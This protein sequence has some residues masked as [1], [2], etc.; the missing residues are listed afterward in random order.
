MFKKNPSMNAMVLAAGL[1]TRLRPLTELIP[2]PLVPVCNCPMLSIVMSNLYR[3]GI[4]G[5][6]V[7]THYLPE[8]I[9]TH[10]H[11][12]KFN[13]YTHIY[14]EPE[15]LGT[16]GPLINAKKLLTRNDFFILHN[17]D[18]LTNIN[19]SAMISHHF[20]SQKK[21]TMALLDGPENKVCFTQDGQVHDILESLG[22]NPPGS[23]KMTY[24]GIMIISIDIFK[25]LPAVPVNCSIIRALIDMIEAEPGVVG[26]YLEPD[27]YWNDL[28]TIEQYFNAHHNILVDHSFSLPDFVLQ[29]N[30]CIDSSVKIEQDTEISGFVSIGADSSIGKR[31]ALCNCIILPGT[32]IG[33]DEFHYNQILTPTMNIHRNYHDLKRLKILDGG[34]F[35]AGQ[36]TSLQEQGSTRGFYRVSA[37]DKSWV[38][39]LSDGMD[40]DFERFIYIGKFLSRFNFPT[41]E[42]YEYEPEEFSVLLE[43]L[44][45]N[46]VFKQ[47]QHVKNIE[48]TDKIY[49]DI[50]DTLLDFQLRGTALFKRS[51]SPI[52]RT[53]DRTYLRWE[54]G[55]FS[56]QFL[57]TFCNKTSD[58]YSRLDDEF[59]ILAEQV[60]NQP[61]IFM[62]RDFQSQNIMLHNGRVRFVDYQGAR[63]G[64]VGYDIM[65]LLNDPY[66]NFGSKQRTR[67]RKYYI[68]RLIEMAPEYSTVNLEDCLITA[69]LQRNMQAL[70][71]YAYLGL[72]VGKKQFLN[73][74]P[75]GLKLLNEGLQNLK[76]TASDLHLP[77][78]TKVVK[79]IVEN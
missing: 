38:L 48:E 22:K 34:K 31:T 56:R 59:D 46:T 10:I 5:F 69:G 65:S 70:G 39:M 3:A 49:Y 4:R 6:A 53:F 7:N 33:T 61:R 21:V 47:L 76:I 54:T 57:G 63:I 35:L 1:G 64:P 62:H 9:N 37:G 40:Q 60:S 18:I 44:G 20:A 78:I 45:N 14:H 77:E 12:S 52:L 68:S 50:I 8:M 32:T 72:T 42:I 19:L 11:Q 27:S 71:A 28:G 30:K 25:Y 43:D 26:G 29:E 13:K 79:N 74:I 67:L 75:R 24:A 36:I 51:D 73:F 58:E 2:K 41:P 66:I 15:I 16:G 17:S 55:Y 23:R